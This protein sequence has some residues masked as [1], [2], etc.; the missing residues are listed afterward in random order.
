MDL[1]VI[2]KNRDYSVFDRKNELIDVN[3][4][5]TEIEMF[6]LIKGV[7]DNSNFKNSGIELTLDNL[8]IFLHAADKGYKNFETFRKGVRWLI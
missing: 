8:V 7:I 5:Y 3:K 6:N 2:Y 1:R 4:N